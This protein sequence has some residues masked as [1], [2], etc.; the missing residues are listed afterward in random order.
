MNS[1][2]DK[3]SQCG[4]LP[5]ESA[6]LG[7]VYILD[8]YRIWYCTVCLIDCC[9]YFDLFYQSIGI[10]Y[11]TAYATV[12]LGF[13]LVYS[14][15]QFTEAKRY[16]LTIIERWNLEFSFRKNIFWRVTPRRR[17]NGSDSFRNL[18]IYFATVT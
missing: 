3:S 16:Q 1:E 6:C 4:V 5:K 11:S 7:T 12:L 8:Y 15:V 13:T 10:R 18:I 2:Y 17:A 9:S 14:R